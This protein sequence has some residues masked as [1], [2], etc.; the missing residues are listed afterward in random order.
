MTTQ[1]IATESPQCLGCGNEFSLAEL[2]A[3]TDPP[4]DKDTVVIE[5]RECGARNEARSEPRGGMDAQPKLAVL[6]ILD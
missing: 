1:F 4:K 3:M 5:C 6:R 2:A